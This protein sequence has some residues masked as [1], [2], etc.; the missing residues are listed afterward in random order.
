MSARDG[1]SSQGGN[2]GIGG[3]GAKGGGGGGG[4]KGGKG[5]QKATPLQEDQAANEQAL[6]IPITDDTGE[7][8][9]DKRYITLERTRVIDGVPT[10]EFVF[11]ENVPGAKTLHFYVETPPEKQARTGSPGKR[12]AHVPGSAFRKHSVNDGAKRKQRQVQRLN[13]DEGQGHEVETDDGLVFEQV[14]LHKEFASSKTLRKMN[15]DTA[16]NAM[17]K[18]MFPHGKKTKVLRSLIP[19]AGDGLF[20]THA[21][22]VADALAMI[23]C[24]TL[25]FKGQMVRHISNVPWNT[26]NKKTHSACMAN[27]CGDLHSENACFVDIDW[28]YQDGGKVFKERT[29]YLMATMDMP[30]GTEILP[31]YELELKDPVMFDSSDEDRDFDDDNSHDTEDDDND[32]WQKKPKKTTATR[33]VCIP[34]S[35]DEDKAEDQQEDEEEEEEEEEDDDDDNDDDYQGEDGN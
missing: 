14:S 32:D 21:V 29:V 16:K 17:Y 10:Q 35:Q 9:G 31:F 24:S 2:G 15:L 20:T 4:A 5:A 33:P 13:Y 27:S 25:D 18:H 1:Q 23:T 12:P 11:A 30:P 3:S 8:V 28:L 19:N 7:I 6:P 22:K 34:S 26:A